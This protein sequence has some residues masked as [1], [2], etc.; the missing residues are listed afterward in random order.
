MEL[1]KFFRRSELS[2]TPQPVRSMALN[3]ATTAVAHTKPV[4]AP[5][6]KDLPAV[7][8]EL[9]AFRPTR[10]AQLDASRR[11]ALVKV[12]QNIPRPPRLLSQL[13]SPDFV[14]SASSSELSDLIA[15]EP[16]LATQLLLTINS[17]LYGLRSPVSSVEQAVK[18]LGLTA[19]RSLCLRY[20]LIH[21]FKAD[22]QQRQDILDA[23]WQASALASE[24]CL[25]LAQGLGYVDTGSLVS[26]VVLTFLGRLA[27]AAAMPRSLLLQVPTR[28]LLARTSAEQALF[29]LASAEI[30][31]LLMQNWGL[32]PT[33]SDEA[34]EVDAVLFAPYAAWDPVRASRLALCY[35]SARLGERLAHD[36]AFTVEGFDLM[37]DADPEMHHVRAYL[38][39]PAFAGVC[40]QLEQPSFNDAIEKQRL[41]LLASA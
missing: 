34:A 20:L 9:A 35:L 8:L 19:V 2:S 31:R 41:A 26:H 32:P 33:V 29:G 5:V 18:L 7:P 13:L 36:P 38:Q 10:A 16:L 30:G 11:Q 40:E 14:S 27:T 25:R 1:L 17:P 39:H 37:Q 6:P 24:I 28:G 22:S 21:A 15:A 23:T 4:M 3:V 12:F